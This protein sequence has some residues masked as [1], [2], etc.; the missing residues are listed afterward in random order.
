MQFAFSPSLKTKVSQHSNN[1]SPKFAGQLITDPSDHT[2][3]VWQQWRSGSPIPPE[4]HNLYLT[5]DGY[6]QSVPSQPIIH[7][8]TPIYPTSSMETSM[9]RSGSP[10]SNHSDVGTVRAY[11]PNFDRKTVRAY[12]PP[13]ASVSSSSSGIMT[14]STGSESSKGTSASWKTI[15]NRPRR[16]PSIGILKNKHGQSLIDR[17][18]QR[19][20]ANPPNTQITGITGEPGS[21]NVRYQ[22][23]DNAM[24]SFDQ[25]FYRPDNLSQALEVGVRKP[26]TKNRRLKAAVIAA[27]NGPTLPTFQ[28]PEGLRKL[29]RKDSISENRFGMPGFIDS[30]MDEEV[31]SVPQ[32][33]HLIGVFRESDDKSEHPPVYMQYAKKDEG[34]STVRIITDKFKRSGKKGDGRFNLVAKNIKRHS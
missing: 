11:S 27:F 33:G 26:V 34:T 20:Y 4:H 2:K 30:T 3:T 18:T 10:E 8:P 22:S 6:Y 7:S 31:H 1:F 19:T 32:N 16:K 12:S 9:V 24:S 29:K 15:P 14:P 25:H 5:S 23:F 17:T 21:Y 28:V 13:P